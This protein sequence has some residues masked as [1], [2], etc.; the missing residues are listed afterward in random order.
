[1]SAM[2]VDAEALSIGELQYPEG[3][4]WFDGEL[5]LSDLFAHS[6]LT[7]TDSGFHN[8]ASIPDDE[9]SGLG[10]LPDGTPL[11]V[12][13]KTQQ[14]RRID[15]SDVRLYA[16][17]AAGSDCNDMLVDPAG[18]CYVSTFGYDLQSGGE[19]KPG[20]VMLVRPGEAS[21][22][23]A[24]DL[25]FP[26]GIVLTSDGRTLIVSELFGGRI[27]AFEVGPAGELG[28][29]RVFADLPGA[30]PDGLCLDAEGAV[31]AATSTGSEFIR[32]CDGG[33]ITHRISVPGEWATSCA[34]G[35]PDGRS[36]FLASGVCTLEEWLAGKASGNLRVATVDVPAAT[37]A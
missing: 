7:W 24:D 29:R 5:W 17:L 13:M 8:R 14:I 21:V 3:L 2:T 10:F 32:V 9:P 16:D 36:L 26:N 4:R 6:V 12:A 11:V 1:V 19:P 34:L 35:G 18:R 30:S 15:G 23:A 28:R 27:T 25:V 31:W 33:E 22:V 37:S 20:Q